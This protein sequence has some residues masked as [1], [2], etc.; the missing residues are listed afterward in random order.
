[1]A[2]VP[3]IIPPDESARYVKG[4]MGTRVGFGAR[5]AILVVDM[6]RPFTEDRF[7]LGCAAAGAPCARASRTLL[8]AARP[9]ELP[10]VYTRYDAFVADAEWGRW[11]DKGTGAE[12]D[13]LIRGS[14]AH[15]MADL[16]KPQARDL[17]VTKSKPSAFFGTPLAAM[18]TYLAADTLIVTGMVT[19]GCV[20]ATVVDAFSHN[21]RVIVP[22]E[23]VADRSLTSHQV[24]LFDMDMKYADVVPLAEVLNHLARG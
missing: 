5:P 23:C 1:M 18:L 20:R 9:L 12:P 13:S 3:D 2:Y 10:V 19:S 4:N 6:T 8:D 22:I 24:N 7:P 15:E 14:E 11:L 21:Y 17:V 16:L